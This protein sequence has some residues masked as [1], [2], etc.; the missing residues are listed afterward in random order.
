MKHSF[1]FLLP[2]LLVTS[3]VFSQ[4]SA[5]HKLRYDIGVLAHDSMFGR[6]SGTQFE[7]RAAY[8][9]AQEFERAGLVPYYSE[10]QS[11]IHNFNYHNYRY[12]ENMLQLKGVDCKYG[13]EFGVV[14]GSSVC[15]TL[16]LKMKIY[17]QSDL[18]TA[19]GIYKGKA[20]L[21]RL[22]GS[23][24]WNRNEFAGAI[25]KMQLLEK[26]GAAALF[27][28]DARNTTFRNQLF[29]ADSMPEF[30][31][32]VLFLSQDLGRWAEE[33][34]VEDCMV[35]VNMDKNRNQ[36]RNVMGFLDKGA[37]QTIIIGAHYDHVGISGP[38][39]AYIGNPRIFNGADDNASG[40]AVM[41]ELARWAVKQSDL[42]YNILF[43]A[44]G[45]EELGLYGSKHFCNSKLFAGTNIAWMLNL[46]MVGRFDWNRKKQLFI[47][48]LGS[49]RD[50]YKHLEHIDSKGFSVKKIKGG[51]AFS[52]HHPFVR[53]G[54][55]VIYFT[56]GLHNE[57]HKPVDDAERI[58]YEGAARITRYLEDLIF[59]MQGQAPPSFRKIRGREHFS[60]VMRLL[61]LK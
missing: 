2:L 16:R 8:Y 30:S 51:P 58:N 57:Y 4:N 41:M 39:S 6:G 38:D 22:N 13:R 20:V 42:R 12:Y 19:A 61:I 46:D 15:D 14:A 11:F 54:V 5:E 17:K 25:E 53:K 44:F 37:S 21:F 36:S 3:G 34:N 1:L 55:P 49:S 29:E 18:T 33:H 32:P 47:L 24:K 56:T 23:K 43:I 35:R 50:W 60:A 9:V 45:A 27:I 10:S 28:Y 7:L 59:Y 26:M 40:T 31:I 48:G 52:D